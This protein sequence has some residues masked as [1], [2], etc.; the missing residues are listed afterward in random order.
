M[1]H[2]QYNIKKT[3]QIVGH[4]ADPSHLAMLLIRVV[5]TTPDAKDTLEADILGRN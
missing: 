3:H 2:G 4:L 5:L 1:M